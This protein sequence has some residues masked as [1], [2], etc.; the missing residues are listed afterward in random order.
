MNGKYFWAACVAFVSTVFLAGVA[1]EAVGHVTY[2]AITD[3]FYEAEDLAA[4][5]E[6]ESLEFEPFGYD[7]F[8]YQGNQ[9]FETDLFMD[10]DFYVECFRDVNV[11]LNTETF[12]E[13]ETFGTHFVFITADVTMIPSYTCVTL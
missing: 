11:V 6:L 4:P 3:V 1:T 12:W 10:G 8:P 7:L 2:D 9:C 5:V 13:F